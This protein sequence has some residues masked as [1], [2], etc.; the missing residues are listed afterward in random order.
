MHG[1]GIGQ[2]HCTVYKSFSVCFLFATQNMLL[3]SLQMCATRDVKLPN[4]ASPNFHSSPIWRTVV[5]LSLSLSPSPPNAE[6][7]LCEITVQF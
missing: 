7:P 5:S 6:T 1:H 3:M 2:K 4:E